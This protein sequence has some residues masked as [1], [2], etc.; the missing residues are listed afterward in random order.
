[1]AARIN[2]LPEAYSEAQ[3]STMIIYLVE[4]RLLRNAKTSHKDPAWP[5]RILATLAL[6]GISNCDKLPA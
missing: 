1:M 2:A 6:L 3:I 5:E 4:D